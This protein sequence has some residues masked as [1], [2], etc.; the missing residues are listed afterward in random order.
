ML[1][2]IEKLIP[3]LTFP[4]IEGGVQGTPLEF[5]NVRLED[6]DEL[7]KADKKY[8]KDFIAAAVNDDFAKGFEVRKVS[9]REIK[10]NFKGL[11]HISS[12]KLLKALGDLHERTAGEDVARRHKG[13]K[14]DVAKRPA[15]ETE[16]EAKS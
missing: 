2:Q 14:K 16:V 10:Q 1:K 15:P 8:A 9:R 7:L 13:T 3:G 4:S 11:V 5:V 12:V 6:H